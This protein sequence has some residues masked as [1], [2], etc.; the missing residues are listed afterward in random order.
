VEVTQVVRAGA[1]LLLL[2][3]DLRGEE[4][5]A[6]F[7][8]SLYWVINVIAARFEFAQNLD[9]FGEAC[10]RDSNRRDRVRFFPRHPWRAR[11]P[12]QMRPRTK[13]RKA[14]ERPS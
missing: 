3:N 14:A 1:G 4:F 7:A 5:G 13:P 10:E 2:Y 11:S 8:L 9:V 12:Q 6:A